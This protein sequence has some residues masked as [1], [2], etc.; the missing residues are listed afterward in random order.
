MKKQEFKKMKRGWVFSGTTW[1]TFQYLNYRG[2]RGRRTTARNW[3]LIWTNSEGKPTLA[4]EI[5]FQEGQEAQ[6]VPKKL[7]PR[8]H[9]PRH[10]IIILPKTED[11]ETI[12]KAARG[13]GSATYKEVP[14]RLS[15]D[16]SKESLQARRGWKEVFEVMNARTCIQ[17]YSIQQSYHLE[18]KGR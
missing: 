18:W 14:T 7:D 9:T 11:K 12:L 15:A 2:A 17:D 16:F 10:I 13:K 8:K 6:R 1:E 3:K 4:K 5:D